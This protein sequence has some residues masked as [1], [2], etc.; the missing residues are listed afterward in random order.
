MKTLTSGMQAHLAGTVTQ[1]ATCWRILRRDGAV[2]AY[3]DHDRDLVHDGIVYRANAGFT[4]SAITRT[5]GLTVDTLD[6]T[7]LQDAEGITE[8]DLR[9][10]LYRHAQMWIFRVCWADPA[11]LGAI[12]GMRG[13]LGETILG[14]SGAWTAEFR[15]LKAALQQTVGRVTSPICDASLGDAR[16][17]VDLESL[18]VAG[19]ITSVTGDAVLTAAIPGAD[20][21]YLD[22]GTLTFS[23]G[24]NTGGTF[25]VDTW[26]GGTLTLW[27]AATYPMAVGDTFLARPGC[28]GQWLT[29]RDIFGNAINHRGQPYL[30]GSDALVQYPAA[31]TSA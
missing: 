23:A 25:E 15:G 3:T 2:R 1:L 13:H 30:T 16:C 7:G 14:P 27:L 18:G 29:C 24:E 6:I 28:D 9:L 11:G 12:R 4:A 19:T 8:R 5:A 21:G 10:G 17:K 26:D 31:G 22:G 20:S